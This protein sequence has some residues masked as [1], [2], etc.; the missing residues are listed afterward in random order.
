MSFMFCKFITCKILAPSPLPAINE[1]KPSYLN[2][3]VCSSPY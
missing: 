2:D 3:P 1:I